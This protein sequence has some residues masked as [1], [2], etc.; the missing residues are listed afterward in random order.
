[1][2]KFSAFDFS[3]AMVKSGNSQW[4]QSLPT[5][6]YKSLMRLI[7]PRMLEQIQFTAI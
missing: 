2:A 5:S 6:C 7:L 1:M 3:V 4:Q